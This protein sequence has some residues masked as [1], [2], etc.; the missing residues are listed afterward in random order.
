MPWLRNGGANKVARSEAEASHYISL[1]HAL[2]GQA[3]LILQLE[4]PFFLPEVPL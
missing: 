1:F 4:Q 2:P 3:S